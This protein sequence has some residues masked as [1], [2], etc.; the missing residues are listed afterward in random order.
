MQKLQ[1]K[2][3][4]PPKEGDCGPG[5]KIFKEQGGETRRVCQ[6][7][8][9]AREE[10]VLSDDMA[11]RHGCFQGGGQTM[12]LRISMGTPHPKLRNTRTTRGRRATS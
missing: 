4:V 12:T 7:L 6:Y 9:E 10:V 5:D 1:T 11:S 2:A 8:P 3:E